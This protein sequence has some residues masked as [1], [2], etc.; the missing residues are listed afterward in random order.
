LAAS[1][2]VEDHEWGVISTGRYSITLYKKNNVDLLDAIHASLALLQITVD[3]DD[4][5]LVPTEAGDIPE[6]RIFSSKSQSN[7]QYRTV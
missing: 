1:L 3:S 5:L 6:T 2:S 4:L 7:H